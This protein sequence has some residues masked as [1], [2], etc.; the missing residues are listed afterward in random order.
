MSLIKCPEC[1]KEISSMADTC[2][3]CGYPIHKNQNNVNNSTA[4]PFPKED[5]YQ[6][7][8]ST[9][10]EQPQRRG[11]SRSGPVF[12][13]KNNLPAWI[14][15]WTGRSQKIAMLWVLP[16]LFVGLPL[17]G[18]YIYTSNYVFLIIA[19]IIIAF[20]MIPSFLARRIK[21]ETRQYGDSVILVHSSFKKFLVVDEEILCK[22]TSNTLTGYLPDGK[23]VTAVISGPRKPIKIEIDDPED[24]IND[25][26]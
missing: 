13:T 3:H 7:K 22:T 17:V 26:E 10:N 19:I 23:R 24:E 14:K 25:F 20:A 6:T 15:K 4:N 21:T 12:N 9:Q 5:S 18:A 1:G 16:D 8:P 2:P 11:G